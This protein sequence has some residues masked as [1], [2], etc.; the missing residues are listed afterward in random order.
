MEAQE[1]AVNLE[2]ISIKSDFCCHH[3]ARIV[4]SFFGDKAIHSFSYEFPMR[5]YYSLKTGVHFT[6]S[7]HHRFFFDLNHHCVMDWVT[8][9]TY[10]HVVDVLVGCLC[11]RHV[12]HRDVSNNASCYFASSA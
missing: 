12:A 9:R 3:V 2:L 11:N 10:L 6:F 5:V 1:I 4:I 8:L 7:F